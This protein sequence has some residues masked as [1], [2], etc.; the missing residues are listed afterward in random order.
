MKEF[1]EIILGKGLFTSVKGQLCLT[2]Q[3]G[4]V[5]IEYPP[6]RKFFFLTFLIQIK[7]KFFF[8]K[9]TLFNEASDTRMLYLSKIGPVYIYYTCVLYI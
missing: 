5:E 6:H 1:N 7:K 2:D 3:E 8:K 4:Q 9:R